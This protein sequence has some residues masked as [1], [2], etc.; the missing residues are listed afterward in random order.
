MKV[1]KKTVVSVTLIAVLLSSGCG[2]FGLLGTPTRHEKKLPA[3]YDLAAR[4]G[5]KL[6]VLV[7]KPAWLVTSADIERRLTE[8]INK[9]VEAR[10]NKKKKKISLVPYEQITEFRS[11]KPE[12]YIPSPARTGEA[13]DADLVLYVVINKYRLTQVT[14]SSYYKGELAGLAE[15]VGVRTGKVLWPDSIEG[16]GIRVAFDIEQG[17][18][19]A[20]IARLAD[21]FA[22]CTIRYFYD[23]PLDEFRI[24]D[25]KSHTSWRQWDD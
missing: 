18:Y 6:L 15:L 10:F 3:E 23:C 22:Y 11:Q 24:F 2:I 17:G 4:S 12:H 13:L 16:K 21:S 5:G 25:D 20:G 14:Q 9:H 19:E 1:I 7:N 8:A